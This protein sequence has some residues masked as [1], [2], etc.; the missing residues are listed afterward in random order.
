MKKSLPFFA[1]GFACVYALSA[2]LTCFCLFGLPSAK[3]EKAFLPERPCHGF[4]VESDSSS[5]RPPVPKPECSCCGLKQKTAV[6][7]GFAFRNL[8]GFFSKK[9]DSLSL[10]ISHFDAPVRASRARFL[11]PPPAGLFSAPIPLYLEIK[12]LRI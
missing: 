12:N 11:K 3:A 7:P 1:S 8:L 5:S 2:A 4:A 6:S 10:A 9:I